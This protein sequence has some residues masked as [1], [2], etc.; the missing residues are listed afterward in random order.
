MQKT[1]VKGGS[2]LVPARWAL[3]YVPFL[4][5]HANL[6]RFAPRLVVC[7][8]YLVQQLSRKY[9]EK[10]H[11]LPQAGPAPVQPY[12]G[13]LILRQSEQ[14]RGK[15]ARQKKRREKELQKTRRLQ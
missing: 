11:G 15:S 6:F 3:T 12:P 13:A 14:Q 2:C 8:K 5:R 10:T 7:A 9:T 4:G 1:R